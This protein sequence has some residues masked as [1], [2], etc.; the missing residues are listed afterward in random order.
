LSLKERIEEVAEGL[1]GT[2]GVAMKNLGT[3]EKVLVKGNTL[4]QLASVF[5]VPVIVT[6]YRQADAGKINLDDYIEMTDYA[7]VPGSGV[8]RELTPGLK[9]KVRDYRTLMMMISDNTATDTIV[10]LV[11]KENV[12]DTMLKLGLQKTKI[13]SCRDIL[14]EFIGL[15]DIAPENRT[16]QLWEETMK[17]MLERVPSRPPRV[18]GK[19][20]NVSTPGEMMML[21]EMIYKG[22]AASKGACDEIIGLM[23][24]CQ[25]GENRI[26]KY[27]PR[28]KVELAHKTGTVRGVVNDSGIVF[29]KNGDPYIICAFAKD[30]VGK[31][32]ESMTSQAMAEATTNGE[33]AIAKVSKIVYEHFTT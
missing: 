33:E 7:R 27:L 2:L 18:K 4:F 11:G 29:P 14:F 22:E 24:K 5:K 9:L 15:G 26:W 3:G 31:G 8:L 25:T 13:S 32:P 6:L 16:I 30:L 12:N 20:D 10:N 28:E 1:R 21:L 23:K 17:K 19:A